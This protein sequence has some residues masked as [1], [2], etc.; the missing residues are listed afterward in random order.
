MPGLLVLVNSCEKE[1]KN[2]IQ[3]ACLDTWIA[4]WG[5]LVDYKIVLPRTDQRSGYELI[6]DAPDAYNQIAYTQKEAY[7]WAIE[8]GYQYVFQ[9]ATDTYICVPRMLACAYSGQEYMGYRVSHDRYAGGGCGFFLGRRAMEVLAVADPSG[10]GFADKWVG[11]RLEAA[12]IDLTHDARYWPDQLPFV[13]TKEQW[14]SGIIGVHLSR[15]TGNFDPK[16]MKECHISCL[17]H[18]NEQDI[19]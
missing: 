19:C 15:G 9:A 8:Q 10:E 7:K 1:R 13:G 3:Q 5:H 14:D 2:G 11:N 18:G 6:V 4:Q 12:G 17:E 16:W